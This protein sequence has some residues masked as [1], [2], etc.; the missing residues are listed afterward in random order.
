MN[1]P[2][3]QG[4]PHFPEEGGGSPCLQHFVP[5]PRMA[6]PC[7]AFMPSWHSSR[8]VEPPCRA[9]TLDRAAELTRYDYR[10]RGN[11]RVLL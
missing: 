11:Q 5:R 10:G 3:Y 8:A 7:C 4:A 6:W 1:A 2:I 9:G